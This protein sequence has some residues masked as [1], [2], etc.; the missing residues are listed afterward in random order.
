MKAATKHGKQAPVDVLSTRALNRALL[1]RQMLLQRR[2][3]PAIEMIAWLVGMQAQ[4]PNNPYVGLWT[5]LEA[6]HPD[7]LSR[8]LLNR[9]AV[10]ILVMRGTI[11]LLTARDCLTLYPLVRPLHERVLKT[12]EFG[13][14]AVDVD[15]ET[16]LAAGR[17]VLE[18]KPRTL[19]ELGARLHEQWPNHEPE[20]LAY[21]VHYGLPLVQIPPRGVWGASMQP[22]L[23]TAEHWL[24]QPLDP[25]PS[26]DEVVLR[27]LAAFGPASAA[28][29]RTW[30]GI[31]GLR[32]VVERLRPQLRVFRDE[33]G[34]E[35]FDLPDA[36][37]PDPDTPAPPR[38]LPE[39]DNVF[40][41]HADRSRIVADEHRKRLATA[42]GV[43]PG[44]F[45]IDGFISGTWRIARERTAATLVLDPLVPLAA[46]DRNALAEE[47]MRLLA[48]A[49]EDAET[50][51]VQF[52]PGD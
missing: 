29:M 1:A 7:E 17:A 24:G 48:F 51:D 36:P 19:K 5:R 39:Y 43:G 2:R 44:T 9:Q 16:L 46:S 47:G 50:R 35:I 30:S 27:Y 14:G 34:R 32:E 25:N 15:T 26:I 23:T 11:H 52:K 4:V 13:R 10:R 33:A 8:L 6:F 38:F 45:L 21:C 18:E 42:N 20:N 37:R 22:T 12:T 28:D 31:T 3:M 41:S 49:A 40:L